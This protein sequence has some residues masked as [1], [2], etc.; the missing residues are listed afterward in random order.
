MMLFMADYTSESI[1]KMHHRATLES[2]DASTS[3]GMT[4]EI[5]QF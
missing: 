4:T 3:V 2:A 5:A 1:A